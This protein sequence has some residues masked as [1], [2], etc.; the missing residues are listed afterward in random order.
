MSKA[1]VHGVDPLLLARAAA[2][3]VLHNG[4][5]ACW[6]TYVAFDGGHHSAE[7]FT[8]SAISV[9]VL[10]REKGAIISSCLPLANKVGGFLPS[11]Q[12]VG[13]GG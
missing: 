9:A 10:A 2:S 11:S 12:A 3:C 1:A 6:K 13:E 5:V 8:A 4:Q 7:A